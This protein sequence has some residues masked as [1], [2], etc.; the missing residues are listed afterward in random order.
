MPTSPASQ[1]IISRGGVI[2]TILS[3]LI[4]ATAVSAVDVGMRSGELDELVI[5]PVKRNYTYIVRTYQ[6]TPPPEPPKQLDVRRNSGQKNADETV[7]VQNSTT[8]E[9]NAAPRGGQQTAPSPTQPVPQPQL[10]PQPSQVNSDFEQSRREMEERTQQWRQE[11]ADR[12]RQLEAESDA[13]MEAFRKEAEE[14]R[15][16]FLEEALREQEER[17]KAWEESQAD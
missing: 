13:R 2:L 1:A 3:F 15:E 6:Y 12:M 10:V 8:I 14:G 4:Y 11:S 5:D 16:A 7:R 17:R 9:I